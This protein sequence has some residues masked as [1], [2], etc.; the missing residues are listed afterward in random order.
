MKILK[1]EDYNYSIVYVENKDESSVYKRFSDGKWVR[2]NGNNWST[3]KNV[4][5]LEKV[6]K[7]KKDDSL[8][9]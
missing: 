2:L 1:I 5:Q 7:E 3:V 9:N 8:I 6:F 4:D